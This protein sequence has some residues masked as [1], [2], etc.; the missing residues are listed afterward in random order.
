MKVP[1]PV[2]HKVRV[3]GELVML[4]GAFTV[5]VAVP[6]VTAPH[7]DEPLIIH[8]YWKLFIPLTGLDTVSTLVDEPV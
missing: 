6:A 1:S 4:A 5:S 3:E 2:V 7:G 8:W